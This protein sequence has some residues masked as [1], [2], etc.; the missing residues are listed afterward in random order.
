MTGEETF[1][2]MRRFRK[3]EY[4]FGERT[5]RIRIPRNLQR[6]NESQ[7]APTSIIGADAIALTGMVWPSSESLCELMLDYNTDGKRFLEIG[8]GLGLASLLLNS[9]GANIAAMDIHPVTAEL[10]ALNTTLNGQNPIPFHRAN[11]SDEALCLGEFDVILGADVLYEPRHV[12]SLPQF[13]ARHTAPGSEVLIVD[14]GRGQA[15]RFSE[16]MTGFGFTLQENTNEF[17]EQH[18]REHS[19]VLYHFKR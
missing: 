7:D 15:E 4:N 19:E 6:L 2:T 10:F 13:L 16:A 9:R 8:C 12:D 14:P 18:R 1:Q 3:A 5:I 11:W 17:A